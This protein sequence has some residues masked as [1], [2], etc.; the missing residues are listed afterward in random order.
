MKAKRLLNLGLMMACGLSLQA[1]TNIFHE[2]FDAA[3]SKAETDVAWYEFINIKDGDE[4]SINTTD[5][6]AGE[7]CMNFFNAN[8]EGN[9]WDRAI[10]FRNLPLQEGKSYRLTYRF[11]GQ[12]EWAIDSETKNKGKM[13]VA[14]MQGGEDADIPLL[15]ANGNEFRYEVSY[16]NP[17][18]YEKYTKMFYF[19]SAQ[20]QKD[21]Y[22]EKNPDKAPLEDKWFATFNIYNPGD[23]YL[24]EVDLSESPIA[25]VYFSE[26]VIRVDFGYATNVTDLAKANPLGRVIM[27]N[28]C[29]SVTLNGAAVEVAA[30]E[31]QSDGYMY[32]FLDDVRSD[33][34]NDKIEIAFK[35]PEDEAYQVKYKGTLAPEGA[36][37]SFGE[38]AGEYLEGLEEVM[39]WAYTEPTKVSTVPVDGSFA[40]DETM[41]EVSFTFDKPVMGHDD[42]GKPLV[43]KLNGVEDLVLKTQ[44]ADDESTTTLTF[45]RKDNKPFTKGGYSITLSGVTSDKN[46]KSFETFTLDF[47][48]GKIQLAETVYTDIT[49]HLLQGENG[50]IPVGWTCMVKGEAGNWTSGVVWEGGSACRNINV[51]GEDGN[52]YVAFYICD[53]DGYT[54]LKYGDKEDAR[55]TLP[56]GDIEFSI[57]GL[58][59]DADVRTLEF[60]LEDMDGNEVVHGSGSTSV[61]ANNFTTVEAAG[62][63]SV[64]FNNPKEQNFI[65]KIHNSSGGWD[66]ARVLG[67]KARSYT[68]TEGESTEASVVF[69]DENY[70]G[71]NK[72]TTADNAAPA[73]GSGW[74]LY[75]K[76]ETGNIKKVPGQDY[77]Y[78]GT[79]IFKLGIKNLT[80]G[81]YTNG[82]WPET[83][84][85]YGSG[86]SESVDNE[87][88]LHIPS[89]RHQITY[90]ASNWKE[91]SANAGR[92]HIVYFELGNKEDGTV[93]YSRE[94]KIENCDMNG[95][96]NA[97]VEAK[98]IQ[99]TI[100]IPTDGDYTIKVGGT[101]EQF[102]GNFKIEKLGSQTAYYN[103]LVNAARKLAIEELEASA[104]EKFNGTTKTALQAAVDKYADLS[105][106]HTPAEATAAKAEL[107]S[108]TK[109]MATRRE[110][111]DRYGKALDAAAAIIAEVGEKEATDEDP[112]HPATKYVNLEAFQ[113]LEAVYN[114]NSAKTAQ[115]QEDKELIAATQDLENNTTWL[116]N[117]R[118]KCVTLLTEQI[119]DAAA[120]LVKLD[121]NTSNDEYVIA[122]GNA[123]T[124][125]QEIAKAL[126]LRVTKAI[127]DKLANG[128]NPFIV[129]DPETKFEDVDSIDLSSFI[130]NRNI[131][132]TE[133]DLNRNLTSIDNLPGWSLDILSGTP[134]VEWSW[135]AFNANKYNPVTNQYL[136]CGWHT[137]F[138]LYQTIKNLPV[139]KY[140]YVAGTQDRGF[141][142][143]TD[144]KKAYMAE[145]QSWH[146]TGTDGTN[147]IEGDILSYIWWQVGDTKDIAG[148]NI[149]KQGQWYG[150]TE[151]VSKQ[152]AVPAVGEGMTGEMTIGAHP[153]EFEGLA[154]VDNFRIY[155]VGKDDTFDYA[156]AANAIAK[157]IET[158]VDEV[159][160]PEGE[161]V[162][163]SFYDLTGK[164]VS[165]PSGI[166]I[167]V[168]T[169]KNGYI[170]VSKILVP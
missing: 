153:K 131:Y 145:N 15:D 9:W 108:L 10:K 55:L 148:F 3:Q 111:V 88:V 132:S 50:K 67:F 59:H 57:M 123:L 126:Q 80:T 143:V 162:N 17:E 40:L 27:P 89:G 37:P 94:D 161:P 1:Q 93:F 129:L 77:N 110:Y 141:S 133:T 165:T 113:A 82:N 18:K 117:M 95:D 26:D 31:L 96:R 128:N 120:A 103:G 112:G 79:R 13:S 90:Y 156:A 121:A 138:D 109:D 122:A 20:L 29:A 32:I 147:E 38:E 61:N 159:S 101:T 140:T 119:V 56:A 115:E 30:V 5:A 142:D 72:V 139:G 151:C 63:I 104:D 25:G 116:T 98:M 6:Y 36:V 16:F 155:M 130:Q 166:T 58:G 11:K 4:Q 136:I 7:G 99:F 167:K 92:D 97:K 45:G 144:N 28:D 53:R 105:N 34:P 23:Y 78:N 75:Q 43:A 70:G 46:I 102:I 150:L 84:A 39:S 154:S 14:L 52:E 86:E 81:Y 146:V 170:K 137:E 66:G 163:V 87:P 125:D 169:Y 134:A 35:N 22:A 168:D 135:V 74:A 127:Y 71:A 51:T 8:V 114:A 41:T 65:L 2:S 76:T 19:A 100:S 24:D 64:K 42:N 157:E 62:N 48:T 107:E 85:I 124:D 164:Q 33:D 47:E 106:M 68:M 160:A 54:Y 158:A 73:V 149:E 21:T 49:T 44:L 152:F 83:Y 69:A 12:N 60:R 118:D 91:N